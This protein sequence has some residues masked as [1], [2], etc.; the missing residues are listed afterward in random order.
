METFWTELRRQVLRV[1]RGG[2]EEEKGLVIMKPGFNGSPKIRL[3]SEIK[4]IISAAP[5]HQQPFPVRGS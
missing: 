5:R 4:K 1:E 2:V 3:P